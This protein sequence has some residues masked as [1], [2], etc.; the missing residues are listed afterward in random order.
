MIKAKLRLANQTV[1]LNT[2][3]LQL[4]KHANTMVGRKKTREKWQ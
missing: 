4:F 2:G 1:Y 3:D